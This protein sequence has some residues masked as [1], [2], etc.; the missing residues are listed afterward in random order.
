MY[1]AWAETVLFPRFP[2]K[3]DNALRFGD[4][5]SY[6]YERYFSDRYV[7]PCFGYFQVFAQNSDITVI[8]SDHDFLT[9]S[10]NLAIRQVFWRFFHCTDRKLAI[11]FFPVNLT[12][13]PW[14]CIRCCAPNLNSEI[15]QPI[16]SWL[17]T[18]LLLVC[19]VTLWLWFLTFWPRTFVTWSNGVTDFIE[20]EQST[21][22]W[23]R[24]KYWKYVAVRHLN[25]TGS[26]FSQLQSL[27]WGNNAPMLNFSKIREPT[28]E[29]SMTESFFIASFLE[30]A[31]CPG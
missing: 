17:V 5:I 9:K 6:N 8:F 28:A 23:S 10:N 3:S 11:F 13:W 7:Y 21:A 20:I 16:R 24:C 31:S 26:E 27:P 19:Y 30:R 18:F 12:W 4:P 15:D 2:K 25:L 22:E 14:T 29:L 1:Y